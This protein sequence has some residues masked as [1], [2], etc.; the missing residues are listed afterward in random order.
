M[1]GQPPFSQ[2]RRDR[3]KSHGSGFAFKAGIVCRKLRV[4]IDTFYLVPCTY[5]EYNTNIRT[6]V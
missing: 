4:E 6:S 5:E 2:S 3:Y 1:T